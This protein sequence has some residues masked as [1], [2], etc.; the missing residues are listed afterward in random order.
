MDWCARKDWD[1]ERQVLCRETNQ[2]VWSLLTIYKEGLGDNQWFPFT[3]WVDGF[4]VWVAEK[5]F[6]LRDA[7]VRDTNELRG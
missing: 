7:N 4:A 2:S 6:V 3:D 1:E 5:G